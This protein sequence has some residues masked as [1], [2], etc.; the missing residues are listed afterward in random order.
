LAREN[1]EDYILD[2]LDEINSATI[3]RKIKTEE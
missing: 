3:Y 2:V 1:K